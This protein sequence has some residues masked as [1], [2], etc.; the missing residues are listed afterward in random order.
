MRASS[1]L[2]FVL[3]ALFACG[4]RAETRWGLTFKSEGGCIGAAELA[5][6]IEK[7]LGRSTFGA[8]PDVRIEGWVRADGPRR[9]R[10]RLTLVDADGTVKGSREVSAEGTSC[11]VIDESLTLVA[12]VM[13]DPGAGLKV[14]PSPSGPEAEWP[15]PEE[16][17]KPVEP[18]P[19]P[20]SDGPRV[21]LPKLPPREEWPGY[22]LVDAG[23]FSQD[24]RWMSR[25]TFYRVVGRPDL[26]AAHSR[27]V[28]VKSLGYVLG[29]TGLSTGL[30]LML[31]QAANIS[32]VR[33]DGNPLSKGNCLEAQPWPLVSGIVSAGVGVVAIVLAAIVNASPTNAKE[34]ADLAESY[35]AKLKPPMVPVTASR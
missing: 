1:A 11:R 4:A 33:Y 26:D 30:V 32:C 5:E 27:R 23:S 19:P 3:F 29:T 24:G 21:L 16:Q 6:A 12:S 15:R 17:P 18:P 2:L 22:L 8:K 31:L 25:S 28:T 9:W 10:A 13:I 35:N 34:D 14:A 7:R 20:S